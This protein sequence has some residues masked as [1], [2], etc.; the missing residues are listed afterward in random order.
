MFATLFASFGISCLLVAVLST[1]VG[2]V[3]KKWIA[4]KVLRRRRYH[5]GCPIAKAWASWAA[6]EIGREGRARWNQ[7]RRWRAACKWADADEARR[8]FEHNLTMARV[9]EDRAIRRILVQDGPTAAMDAIIA[10]TMQMSKTHAVARVLETVDVA[11]FLLLSE[12]H[13]NVAPL[14]MTEH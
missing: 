10:I 11:T 8:N 7:E 3:P 1:L 6:A 5:K 2:M 9:L 14:R 12:T 4:G 13:R